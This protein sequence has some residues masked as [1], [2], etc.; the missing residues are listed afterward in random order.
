MVGID[1]AADLCFSF[2]ESSR[3]LAVHVAD[4]RSNFL[5]LQM[6]YRLARPNDKST[7]KAGSHARLFLRLARYG[8][9]KIPGS[10]PP[11]LDGFKPSKTERR[12]SAR[13]GRAKA[14]PFAEGCNCENIFWGGSVVLGRS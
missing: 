13:P 2:T 5:W 9:G 1:W 6:A 10:L 14:R 11:K 8:R 4:G 12:N 7:S 3:T